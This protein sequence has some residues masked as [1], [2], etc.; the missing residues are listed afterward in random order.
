LGNDQKNAIPSVSGRNGIFAKSSCVTL[1]DK[2]HS[3]EAPKALN[4]DPLPSESRDPRYVGSA[5]CP[6]CLTN[7]WRAKSC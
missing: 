2:V 1:H 6:E 7:D 5:M 3:C 4:V